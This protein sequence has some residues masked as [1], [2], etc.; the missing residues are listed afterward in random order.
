MFKKI[1]ELVEENAK[2]KES[3]ARVEMEQTLILN[4]I[5]GFARKIL[6]TKAQLAEAVGLLRYI[7]NHNEL[8]LYENERIEDFLA[9][10]AQAEDECKRPPEGWK[11]SRAAEHQG[12][13]AASKADPLSA[14]M[15]AL[16]LM[17]TWTGEDWSE[18]A[19][20]FPTLAE[21]IEGARRGALA[22]QPD[23]SQFTAAADYIQKKADDYA[24]EHGWDDMGVLSFGTGAQGVAKME[25]FSA[26]D[27]L[28]EELRNLNAV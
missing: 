23:S 15:S 3:L 27:E 20:R 13:C 22:T 1:D 16:E 18:M 5:Q 21:Q 6:D 4:D 28:A 9:R 2:L 24:S 7:Y 14:E 26:L 10:H 25:H 11:C 12:P 19:E 17:Q 8:A